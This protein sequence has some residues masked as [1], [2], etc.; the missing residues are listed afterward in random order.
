MELRKYFKMLVLAV[1]CITLIWV[2]KAQDEQNKAN[3][4]K[5]LFVNSKCNTCHSVGVWNIEQKNKSPNNKAPDLSKSKSDL[6]KELL[7]KYLLKEESLNDKK[8]PVAFKGSE[9]DL[10]TLVEELLLLTK[11]SNESPN[12]NQENNQEQK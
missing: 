9:E 11:S 12:E 10:Q 2:L 3:L 5:E 1:F 7:R 6:D 8:H 4:G